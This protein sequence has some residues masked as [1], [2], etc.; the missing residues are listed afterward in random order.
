[1]L[2]I[3]VHDT[4][5]HVIL[6]L[7]GSLTGNWVAELEDSWRA[8]SSN[9]ASRLLFLD[10]TAVDNVDNAGRYLLALLRDRGVRLIVSGLVMTDLVAALAEEWRLRKKP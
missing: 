6:K 5:Q 2:R 4:P 8:A 1:M 10:L 9:L 3:T 7:E